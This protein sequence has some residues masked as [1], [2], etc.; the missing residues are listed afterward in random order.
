[1]FL[2]IKTFDIFYLNLVRAYVKS[3]YSPAV[4]IRRVTEVVEQRRLRP[5]RR[6]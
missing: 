2:L 4:K 5:H 3:V 1:M 6:H